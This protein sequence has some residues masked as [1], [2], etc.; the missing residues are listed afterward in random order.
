[1][2]FRDITQ[3]KGS[4]QYGAQMGRHTGPDF[5]DVDAGRIYLRRVKLDRGGYDQGGAYW[6]IGE[7]LWLAQDQDGNCRIFRAASRDKAKAEIRE[8][9]GTAAR[10]YR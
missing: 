1:M 2:A 10:F 4:N 3:D 6:G 5:L 7:P 9:F 8:T